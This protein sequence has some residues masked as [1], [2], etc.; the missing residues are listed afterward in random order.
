MKERKKELL[1]IQNLIEKDRLKAGDNFEKLI[2]LDVH[3]LLSDYFEYRGLPSVIIEKEKG[4]LKV[5][6]EL[7]PIAIKG[8]GII[9]KN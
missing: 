3:K 6:I 5:L 7:N 1:R 9:P 8:F 2:Q 4:K